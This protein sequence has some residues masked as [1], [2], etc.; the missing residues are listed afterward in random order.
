L[1]INGVGC[2]FTAL[3][4]MLTITLKFDEGGWV[5]IAITGGLVALC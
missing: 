1:F 4:L 3:I 2:V 5:T